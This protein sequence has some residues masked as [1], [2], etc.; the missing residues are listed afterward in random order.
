MCYIPHE[1]TN[2]ITYPVRYLIYYMRVKEAP[3]NASTMSPIM[4]AH[5][6]L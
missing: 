2:V 3:G 6:L 1:T 5:A 4:N